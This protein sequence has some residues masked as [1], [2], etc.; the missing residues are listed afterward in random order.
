[1][2]RD[3]PGGLVRARRGPSDGR[4]PADP[5]PGEPPRRPLRTPA[6][7]GRLRRTPGELRRTPTDPR[8][9]SRA[10]RDRETTTSADPLRRPPRIRVGAREGGSKCNIF[11]GMGL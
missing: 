5:G 6:N 10:P 7:P 8:G 9:P 1:M 11:S 2:E 4:P 3:S